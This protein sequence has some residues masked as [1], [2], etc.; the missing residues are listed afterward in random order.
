MFRKRNMQ[1]NY[2]PSLDTNGLFFYSDFL[3]I[4]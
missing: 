3:T 2:V 4:L 1:N